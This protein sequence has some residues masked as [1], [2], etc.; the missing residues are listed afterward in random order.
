[1]TGPYLI[2]GMM[3]FFTLMLCAAVAVPAWL[4]M[5]K[6]MEGLR[7][8]RV[9]FHESAINAIGLELTRP[10][11]NAAQVERLLD[12]RQRNVAALLSLAPAAKVPPMPVVAGT[13]LQAAA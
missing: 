12:Q 4:V 5:P 11:L 1:M 3:A 2:Y 6:W 7:D 10:Q 13:V 8:R 9:A